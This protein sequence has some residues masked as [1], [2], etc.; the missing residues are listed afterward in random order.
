ML[1]IFS[2]FDIGCPAF[3]LRFCYGETSERLPRRSLGVG[4]FG[5]CC[6]ELHFSLYT[7]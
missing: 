5:V 3:L 7:F 4:G 1:S 6:D 2:A